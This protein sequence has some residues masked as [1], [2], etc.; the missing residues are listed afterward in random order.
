M[1]IDFPFKKHDS[2][3]SV[4][5]VLAGFIGDLLLGSYELLPN[6]SGAFYLQFMLE[7]LLQL[8]DDVTL[9]MQQIMWVL[10]DGAPFIVLAMSCSIQVDG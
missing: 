8:L 6:L 2:S 1:K 7:Q 5:L 4:Q 9:A 10:Y 3:S